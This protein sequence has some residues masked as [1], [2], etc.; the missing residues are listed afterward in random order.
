MGGPVC[1]YSGHEGVISSFIELAPI[2]NEFTQK[3]GRSPALGDMHKG[4]VKKV[5]GI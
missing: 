3:R 5:L 4:T 1:C 2:P